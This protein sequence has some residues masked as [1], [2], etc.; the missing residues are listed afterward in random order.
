MKPTYVIEVHRGW[1]DPGEQF[2]AFRHKAVAEGVMAH[3]RR[4]HALGKVDPH[5][6]GGWG[7]HR[8]TYTGKSR[9]IKPMSAAKEREF[10]RLLHDR[11]R[12]LARSRRSR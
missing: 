12:I 4:H 3:H 2:L 10:A 1:N 7:A 6:S 11:R 5:Y 8:L 9:Y